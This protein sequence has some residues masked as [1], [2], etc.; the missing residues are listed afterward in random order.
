MFLLS[1]FSVL[2]LLAGFFTYRL[3]YRVWVSTTRYRELGGKAAV[4]G[5]SHPILGHMHEI[6]VKNGHRH[7]EYVTEAMRDLNT[8]LMCAR[9]GVLD[10]SVILWFTSDPLIVKHILKDN[11]DNYTKTFADGDASTYLLQKFLGGGI[12]AVSHGPTALDKGDSWYWQRKI[13]SQM[14]TTSEFKTFICDSFME[15]ADTLVEVLDSMPSGSVVDLQ[16][17]FFRYTM[18]AFGQIA[19]DADFDTMKGTSNAYGEAFDGAHSEFLYFSRNHSFMSALVAIWPRGSFARKGIE[20]LLN[21]FV[22]SMQ[23]FNAHRAVLKQYT[24]EVI[25][26]RR[27]VGSLAS[28]SK[29]IL[30][31]FIRACDEHSD[32][33]LPNSD[34]FLT[35]VVLNLIIAGRDTTACLLSWT[36]YELARN[37]EVLA[38][39][40]SELEG[41]DP[42][43]YESMKHQSYLK[44]VFY[45]VQRLWPSVPF[46]SKICMEDDV[47]P[48][49]QRVRVGE[50]VGF[51]PYVMGRDSDLYISPMTFDPER[52]LH[53]GQFQAPNPYE[54]PVFQAG[55]RVCLG[56]NFALMEASVATT[57]LVQKFDLKLVVEGGKCLPDATKVTMSIKGPLSMILTPRP[58]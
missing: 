6:F 54:Y 11:F 46:D 27:N 5:G 1:L 23:R 39:L 12:F 57:K 34:Q 21:L 3:L 17:Y 19:F 25:R 48:G 30:G 24:L 29:D 22:H 35:D 8:K 28:R 52:W 13:T 58:S 31:L 16:Q 42:D 36:F 26:K 32:K 40:R 45:E 55:P 56:M 9:R 41:A 47:L 37:P 20:V 44:A 14:F 33:N 10:R 7:H 38:K 18:D 53:D 2:A 51:C 43:D 50:Q 4:P 15:K 49:G